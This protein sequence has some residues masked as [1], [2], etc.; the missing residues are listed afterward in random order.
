M[1]N[2]AQL[3]FAAIICTIVFATPQ[4]A[5]G[6]ESADTNG[7]TSVVEA[8]AEGSCFET[9]AACVFDSEESMDN[10]HC[11][12]S[13]EA[14]ENAETP[15]G[16]PEVEAPENEE[17]DCDN[18]EGAYSDSED[19]RP[20]KGSSKAE[21]ASEHEAS[22]STAPA[23]TD[24]SLVNSSA[25]SA[26]SQVLGSS[27]TDASNDS[28]NQKSESS[29]STAAQSAPSVTLK[30]QVHVQNIGWQGW[31]SATSNADKTG[32]IIVGTEGRSLRLEAIQI[33]FEGISGSINYQVHIQDIGWQD[34]KVKGV[35]AGTSGQ[36]RRLEAVRIVLLGDI[37]KWYDIEYKA[38]VQNNGWESEYKKNGSV[39]G[40]SG[41]S[42]R[43]EAL[44]IRLVPKKSPS[45]ESEGIV[46]V[47]YQ[48]HV[49]NV[50]NQAWVRDGSV[51]GTT[52]QSLRVEAL[53]VALDK[54]KYS[55]SIEYR[56]HIQNKGWTNWVANG[57][58]AGT[59]GQ[60]L[61]LEAFE[62][63]LAGNISQAYEV[64]YRAHVQ[65]VGWQDWLSAGNIAGTTGRGLRLEAFQVQLILRPAAPIATRTI[66]DGLYTMRMKAAPGN[67]V[68]VASASDSS[69]ANAQLVSNANWRL[70]E[71]WQITWKGD[72]YE[73]L[74]INSGKVLDALNGSKN[75]VANVQQSNRSNSKSQRWTFLRNADG[76][77]SVIGMDKGSALDVDGSYLAEGDNLRLWSPN[78][79]IH[80]KFLI[81]LTEPFYPG[82]YQV[83]T[84]LNVSNRS[85][86][87]PGGSLANGVQM[88]VDQ[89]NDGPNQHFIFSREG[90]AYTIQVVSSGKYL[91]ASNGA[92]VQ[93]SKNG[94]TTQLWKWSLASNGG[95]VFTNAST[96][97]VM[98]V[99][100]NKAASATKLVLQ[101]NGNQAGQR[102]YPLGRSLVSS[103]LYEIR[104][105]S[106]TK[107]VLDVSGGSFAS[108]ANVEVY[109]GNGGNNQKF[110]IVHVSDGY[111]RIG[112]PLCGTVLTVQGSS[113][114]N[115]ANLRMETWASSA[116]QLWKPV[117]TDGGL[118]F[119]NKNSGMYVSYAAAKPGSNVRQVKDAASQLQRWSV[120][121]TSLN[122]NDL[123]SFR[124]AVQA[125]A[126]GSNVK[127][128][129]AVPGYS[130]SKANWDRLVNALNACWNR[131]YD[132]GFLMMDCNTGMTVSLNADREYYGASTIK[133]LWVTYLFEE[134]LEKGRLSWGDISDLA[135]PAITVSDNYSY[136]QLRANYGSESGFARWLDAVDVGYIPT[137]DSYT[138]RTLAKAW[139]HMLAYSAS[140]GAYASTWRSLF[141]DSYFSAI[142]DRLGGYRTVYSKPGW[143]GSGSMY[144]AITN[145]A[146][147]VDD[148]NGRRYLLV[149]MSH[150][151]PFANRYLLGNVAAA[152]DAIHMEMPKSR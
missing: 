31:K 51:Q 73:L 85:M 117:V 80:Q 134:Y 13:P 69:G 64:V 59:T 24:D 28:T 15:E 109:T 35:I 7:S 105:A 131:G 55:G 114:A 26:N 106:S 78:E 86:D 21:S 40:T 60:S 10:E 144:G 72:G 92:I 67:A 49:Q 126:G 124:M 115:E 113:K 110:S 127:L 122:Q 2:T 129:N 116:S 1:R 34:A 56:V 96:N 36:S 95:L 30:A 149:L 147:V 128:A 61:R 101:T 68:G 120:V 33:Q 75:L 118:R 98:T 136:L 107:L 58:L 71:K 104:S 112:M 66:D 100:G 65:N 11:E 48:D 140:G 53:R 57:Q 87:V 119:V 83:F 70:E 143:M 148:R 130:I 141:D 145:D 52:G 133:G 43:L 90:D 99:Q 5:Y 137:W 89:A 142:N 150:V 27:A 102:W 125:A 29:T 74:N 20:A 3:F 45:S 138:P 17:I 46:G 37:S 111:Y 19:Q 50:G 84:K 39:S 76:S 121:T 97:S 38:H 22:D 41:K 42:L 25:E 14:V 94:A 93:T 9:N 88:V 146:A 108:G 91:T 77:Y 23:E 44:R 32:E 103:G 81:A 47:R 79:G 54:G 152:L 4:I 123:L 8:I 151:E 82:T 18:G 62:M 16:G 6:V 63:R 135:I 139:T 132:V 12:A